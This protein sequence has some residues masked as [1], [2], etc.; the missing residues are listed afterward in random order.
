MSGVFTVKRILILSS[1]VACS[2]LGYLSVSVPIRE[3]LARLFSLEYEIPVEVAK[4]HKKT[5]GRTLT[6]RGELL[7]FKEVRVNSTISGIIRE[8]RFAA[9]DKVAV[10]AVIA[11]IEAKDLTERL[12]TQ[13][14]AIK[15]AEAQIKRSESQL[16]AAE[17]QL[18]ATR[19]LF[20]KNFIA[21][22]EVELAEAAA[23]TAR[24]QKE[25][26]EAQLAQRI[27]L[28]AQ[29]RHI[30][31]LARITAP[32]AGFVSRRWV[33]PGASV[34]ESAPLISISQAGTLKILSHVKNVDLEKIRPGTAAQVVADAL[35]DKVFR[36]KVTQVQE[37]ANFTGDESSVEVEVANPNGALKI[38]MAAS[39]SL[40]LEERRD[41]IF[42]PSGALV[43][44]QGQQS[45]VFVLE[46]GK[47]RQKR[48]IFG[49]EQ[50]GQIEVLSG[51]EPGQ[52]VIVKGVDRLRDGSRVLAVE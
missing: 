22:R 15:E 31:T 36:G 35:P 10:G 1:I 41:G 52:I 32:V 46:N 48:V 24:A 18:S 37:L 30:L 19:D 33:E 28:S 21:R 50:D 34:A 40:P 13:E 27:S 38:G 2:T 43:P 47:A 44:T 9:G 11:I 5:L 4:A 51:L 23:A 3:R 14:A 20:Q 45:H 12:V 39:A 42:V 49:K 6:T 25:V 29:T 8:M 7:A 17:K 16:V 26:A